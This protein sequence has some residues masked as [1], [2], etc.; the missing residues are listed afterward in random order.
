MDDRL[1]TPPVLTEEELAKNTAE[2]AA[3]ARK[4]KERFRIGNGKVSRA[5]AIIRETEAMF[6][7]V[8]GTAKRAAMLSPIQLEWYVEALANAGDFR[9]AHKFDP[10][11]GYDKVWKAVWRE[12]DKRCKCRPRKQMKQDGQVEEYSNR[13]VQK[14]IHS[15]KHNRIVNL[16]TC[17]ECGFQNA[18]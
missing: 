14:T 10:T 1:P 15:L 4:F 2:Q 6:G 18:G 13:F 9:T 3:R 5:M 8:R 16:Y 17:A 7:K 12:D 11:K